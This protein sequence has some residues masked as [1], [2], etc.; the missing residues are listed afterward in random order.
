M[1]DIWVHVIGDA[2]TVASERLTFQAGDFFTDELPRCDAYLLMDVL[3]D[4]GD[5]EAVTI[6]QAIR[7]A[8]PS[9]A[10]L[11]ICELLISADPGPDVAK[12]LDVHMMA[13]LGGRQRTRQ[14]N[15][16]LLDAAG[17]AVNRQIDTA[18]DMAI[19]EAVTAP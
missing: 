7:R 13:M 18:S 5:E 2:G 11:L 3:H 6:L 4:W 10:K 14:H 15:E 19:L 17:F 16:A 12:M 1:S 8:A 9:H